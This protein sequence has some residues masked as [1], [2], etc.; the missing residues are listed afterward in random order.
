MDEHVVQKKGENHHILIIGVML[1]GAFIAVLNQTV[2]SPA[3][4]SIMR[5]M[6][7][8]AV[9]GQWLTTA[10]MLVNGIMIPITAYLINRFT[11]RQIFLSSMI[12]FTMGTALAGFSKTFLVLLIARILQAMAAGILMP[13]IQTVILLL[14]PRE[15]RGSAMGTVGIVIAFA[16]AV[17]PTLSGWFVDAWG[18]NSIFLVIAPLAAIDVLFGFGLLKNVGETKKLKLDQRSVIYST[19]GFGGL[20]Y[21]CSSA[22]SYGWFHPMTLA[23]LVAGIVFL[24][25][26][27]RRQLKTENPLLELKILKTRIFAY[28][29]IIAMIVNASLIAGTII[30]PIYLQN[31]LHFSALQSGLI[32]LPGAVLMG[33]MSPITG[34]LFDRFGPRGIAITGLTIMTGFS[35]F[36]VFIDETWVFSHLCIIYTVRLFGMSMVNMPLTTWGLNSLENNMIAHGSAIN[37]TARQVAGSIGTAILI[38]IMA[39]VTALNQGAGE[40]EATLRGMHAAYGVAACLGVVALV[41]AIL[42]VKREKRTDDIFCD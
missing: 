40:L 42:F 7:I 20:L 16:P 15:K 17:G 33:I 41:M 38:T 25:V 22:G 28:S 39:M 36:F 3:L 13:M 12:L 31:V 34:N 26:F 19:L 24:V 4:P 35:F 23:P 6:N 30:T 14:F 37:N 18:W 1:S 9:E 11:T 32:M 27:V 2:L 8:T 5:D 10:F 29:T 21:G